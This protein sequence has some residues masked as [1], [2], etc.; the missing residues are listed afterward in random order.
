DC[1]RLQR[2][3]GGSYRGRPAHYECEIAELQLPGNRTGHD[4]I[5]SG[6]AVCERLRSYT[7]YPAGIG[8][9][10]LTSMTGTANQIE[11]AEQ[12]KF[13]VAM[14]FDR[15]AKALEAAGGNRVSTRAVIQIL[16][17]KRAEVMAKDQAGYFIVEWQELR[18][19]VRQLIAQDSRYKAIKARS[20]AQI[21]I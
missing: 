5:F 7:A 4:E 12:I 13:R 1:L 11:W 9:R 14:E 2:R 21:H 20:A 19:Q 10:G 16:E 8:V 15:V 3:G 6:T 17:D 18:D